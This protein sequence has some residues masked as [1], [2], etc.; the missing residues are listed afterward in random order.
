MIRINLLATERKVA[1]AASPGMQAGQK[2]MVIGS[3]VLVVTLAVL[4]WRYWA[5][6]Q[7]EAQTKRDIDAANRV[8]EVGKPHLPDWLERVSIRHLRVGDGSASLH[9]R[10]RDRDVEVHIADVEGE[11]RLAQEPTCSAS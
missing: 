5:L 1:K 9:F 10:R 8:I 3:L 2:M 6:G 4:G 7:Q 11:I